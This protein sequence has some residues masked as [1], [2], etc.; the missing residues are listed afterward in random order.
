MKILRFVSSFIF[1]EFCLILYK[2][3]VTLWGS[4][5]KYGLPGTAPPFSD[6]I[7]AI[8]KEKR[9]FS[10]AESYFIEEITCDFILKTTEIDEL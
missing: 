9:K 4:C 5:F 3:T 8:D 7:C 10:C 1:R 2:I 6:T